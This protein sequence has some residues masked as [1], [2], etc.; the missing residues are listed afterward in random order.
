MQHLQAAH[1]AARQPGSSKPRANSSDLFPRSN[2]SGVTRG[3]RHGGALRD[4]NPRRVSAGRML[5]KQSPMAVSPPRCRH[6]LWRVGAV[7]LL[8]AAC[9]DRDGGLPTLTWYV[10]PD[11]GGQG[12][13][14]EKCTR[15]ANGAYRIDVQVLPTAADAQREQLVRRLAGRDRSIDLMSL[16]PPFVAEFANAGFLHVITHA[17][18]VAFFTEGVLEAPRQAAYW[19][20]ALVA[21]PLWANTQ[22]LWFRKSIAAARGVRPTPQ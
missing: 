13:L 16:D 3:A 7:G 15:E 21:A 14:A 6:A 9:G 10:N 20:G 2:T 17:E 1:D 8:F 18:D 19:N 5:Q 11:N 4:R 22:L 12:R